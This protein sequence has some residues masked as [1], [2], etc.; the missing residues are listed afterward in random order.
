MLTETLAVQDRERP[1]QVLPALAAWRRRERAESETAA[2]RYRVTWAPVPDPAPAALTGTWL[3]VLPAALT[4]AA[5]V[6]L[7]QAGRDDFTEAGLAEACA[8][9]LAVRGARVLTVE[10]APGETDRAALAGLISRALA[11]PRDGQALAGPRDLPGVPGWPG[12][13]CGGGGGVVSLLALAREPDRAFPVVPSGLA[14]TLGLVQALGDAGITAPL[15]VL[16]RGAVAAGA[17]DRELSPVQAT[18]WG[19]GRVVGLEHPDRWGGLVD[20]PP[21]LDERAAGRLAGVLAGCGE[22]QVAIRPGGVLARRLA[23][24]SR[25]GGDPDGRGAWVPRGSVL[26]T[27]GTGAIAGHVARWLAG[28]GAG[29]IVL[30]SRSGPG[31]A[32]AAALAAGLAP[33]GAGVAVIAA[34]VAERAQVAGVLAWIGGSGPALTA[35]MHTAGAGQATPVAD[36]TVAELAALMAAK[37]AGAAHLDELT[38]DLDLDAFVLFS[39]IS[40]TW[41][42]GLQPGYAAANAFLDAL[43]EQRR[44][45]GQAA[46]SVAW[47]LWGGGGM[48]AGDGR[49]AASAARP[50][51]DGPGPRGRRPGSGARPRR[52]AGDGRGRGLGAVRPGVHAAA[53]EPADRRPARGR[54]GA[55]RGRGRRRRGPAVGPALGRRLAGAARAEQERASSTWSRAEAATVLGHASRGG[56]E[57]G[58]AFRELGFD[59]LTAVELRNQLSASTGLRLPATLVFD[60]PTPRRS[61]VTCGPSCSARPR[62]PARA[63]RDRPRPRKRTRRDRGHGLPVPRRRASPQDL[64]DLLAAGG[65]AI[66]GFPADRGWDDVYDPDPGTPGKS[67]AREGG[68]L[69]DAADFDPGFFGISPREAIAMDPQQRLLLEMSWEALEGAGIAPGALRGTP[70]GVFAGLIYHDYGIGVVTAGET[71]GGRGLPG[72]RRRRRAWHPGGSRTCSAW[73]ARR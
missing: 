73:R 57:A 63:A 19:L 50:A 54:P 3:L 32:G 53:A 49:R 69:Y 34:D 38:R 8:Q 26:V 65:D 44:G 28:G 40:A 59:S 17:D 6:G 72:Q 39:S 46:T 23:R 22:D 35:V 24:V 13:R 37:A 68:F 47:G 45:R 62:R 48:G 67:Y 71:A 25:L 41:G 30:S 52:G 58:R 60:Y 20:L 36:A 51:G 9:A 29:R 56:R 16:T 15:W 1:E 14:G 66:A 64:W 11:G 55:G 7:T 10:T 21:V 12:G 70:T 2:W 42:S 61:P 33:A 27:G 5:P 18:A 31:A 4:Q 43:A